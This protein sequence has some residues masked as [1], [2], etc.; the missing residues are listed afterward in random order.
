MRL[1][2]L[3]GK[4]LTLDGLV[5]VSR[6]AARASLSPAARRAMAASRRVVDRA[7]RSHATVYGV[8]TGFGKFADV[9]IPPGQIAELQRNLIRSH[10]AGVGSPLEAPA[11]RAMMLLRSNALAKGNSGIRVATVETL[12]AMLAADILPVI[13]SQG[14]VGASGD[15]APLSHLALALMGEGRVRVRGKEFPA[16]QALRRARI[17]PVVLAAKEGLALINGVQMSVAIGGLALARAL[18][19]ARIADVIGAASV[20]ASR[21]SDT[22]FDPRIVAA[23]P[24]PGA[25]AAAKNLRALLSGSAIRESHRG[26]GRV[27]DNYAL[28]CMPQVHG[29]ARDAFDHARAV[30]EREMNSATD[31]PLVFA[32]RGDILSGG[33]FHGAPVGLVLDY[34]GIAATDLASISERR[35][36]KLVNPALSD[37][38]AFLVSEGGLHSGLMIAQV[39]AAAL[40]SECKI[41]AHPAS[42]DSIPTSA[43][44]EDHVSMSP[45]AARKL[46]AIVANLELVLA[47]EAIAAF[48]AMEFLRPLASSAPLEKV[49]REFRRAVRP[50]NQDREMHADIESARTFL[51]GE[52][53]SRAIAGLA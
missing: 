35:I 53:M 8:T 30:L 51:G 11:V 19:L 13:P 39:T 25:A 50:W 44:K 37:L 15:L 32:G 5:A 48:Q 27:Q 22:A 38:P 43:A 12:L 24:H 29:A 34:A 45:I 9:S 23:R 52:A 16:A 1:L 49:R 4:D 17:R 28:R 26:C 42:V 18:E 41:L 7:V 2:K 47:I 3:S 46:A 31:N 21:G 6:R 10:C 40:V 36:E 20:D 33:N 14:S